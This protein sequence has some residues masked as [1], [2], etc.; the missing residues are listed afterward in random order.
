MT[1]IRPMI[2]R[3]LAVGMLAVAVSLSFPVV[4]SAA[5]GWDESCPPAGDSSGPSGDDSSESSGTQSE[6][7][8]STPSS[9]AE[10]AVSCSVYANGGGMGSY[11][12][13]VGGTGDIKSLR[14]RFPG[15]TLQ[16]CRYRPV[17]PGIQT[18]FNSRKGEGDY[19]VMTCLGN[20]DFDTFTGGPA[21]TLDMSVVFVNNG[22]DTSD[23]HN[24]IT[25]YLWNQFESSASTQL[26]VPFMRTR[27]SIVPVVGVPTFFTFRWL[28]P[29][30]N[31]VVAEGPYAG[32]ANGG[33]FR[34]VRSGGLLMRAEATAITINPN[35][36][37]IPSVSCR[38]DTPYREG[39]SPANQPEGACDIN[40]PR[41]SAS[42]RKYATDPIPA[43]VKD[44]FN[45][46]V[47][48]EWRITYGR[49]GA[50]MQAL[51]NGFMMRV[52]QVLPVQEIQVPNQPPTVIY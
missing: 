25:D 39:A 42:A 6:N 51:G 8:S 10:P 12:V 3:G 50:D 33:P 40:F 27:P 28:N 1:R 17:P 47:E 2:A 11:C 34:E 24:G 9:S 26:P 32:E 52:K 4:A 16:R 41:S 5:C 20:I 37:G 23:H 31:S 36:K 7:Y 38:P 18:P 22:T 48:V 15:Q 49:G 30:D 45:V 35:Q 19:M 46:S 44:A 21:R 13:S 14:E 43:N 29:A